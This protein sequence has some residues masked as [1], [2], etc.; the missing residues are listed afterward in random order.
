MTSS[1]NFE[2]WHICMSQAG[3]QPQR[4]KEKEIMGLMRDGFLT[5]D[6]GKNEFRLQQDGTIAISWEGEVVWENTVDREDIKGL[7]LQE[8]GNFVLYTHD[9]EAVWASNTCGQG[10]EVYLDVQD[11]GNVV[12]YNGEDD[13]PATV[14]VAN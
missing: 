10:A 5:S 2:S 4:M 7:H 6:N 1:S 8:D 9:D 14:W 11:D 3:T 13:E 12:L